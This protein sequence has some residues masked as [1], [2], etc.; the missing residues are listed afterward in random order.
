MKKS[1]PIFS[2]CMI[3]YQHEQ[4]IEKAIEGILMQ[5]VDFEIELVI[6]DDNSLDKTFSIIE[7]FKCNHPN[8][9]WIKYFKNHVNLGV[10][11]NFKQALAACRGQYIALCEGDDFWIDKFHLKN[12]FKIFK[13]NQ[14]ILMS[15]SFSKIVVDN[16][17]KLI[18]IGINPEYKF[19]DLNRLTIQDVLNGNFY[20]STVTRVYPYFVVNKFVEDVGS[21]KVVCEWLLSLYSIHLSAQNINSIGFGNYIAGVYRQSDSG[22]WHN[23]S[24]AFKNKSDFDTV[25]FAFKKGWNLPEYFYKRELLFK[26]RLLYMDNDISI[27]SRIYFFIKFWQFRISMLL[28]KID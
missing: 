19:Y 10:S 3:T 5:E 18:E 13:T 2:V 12:Q 14:N 21:S 17:G 6:F 9:K 1:L 27:I 7:R 26:S 16:H 23:K 4:F 28:I 11:E 20:F 22:A 15:G 8:G 25:Y 24:Q